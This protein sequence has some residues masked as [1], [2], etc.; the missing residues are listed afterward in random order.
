MTQHQQKKSLSVMTV[1]QLKELIQEHNLGGEID[2]DVKHVYGEILF[3]DMLEQWDKDEVK[4][5][6]DDGC[7]HDQ[8]ENYYEENE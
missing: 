7:G 4:E 2:Y 8:N 6:K 3:R 1:D 5:N